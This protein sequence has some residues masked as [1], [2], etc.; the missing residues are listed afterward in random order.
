MF[1]DRRDHAIVG[2]APDPMHSVQADLVVVGSGA[3]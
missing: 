2:P 1:H 3:A